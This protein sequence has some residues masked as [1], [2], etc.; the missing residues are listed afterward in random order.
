MILVGDQGRFRV[1]VQGAPAELSLIGAHFESKDPKRLAVDRNT[2]IYQALA[3]GKVLVGVTHPNATNAAV[4]NIEI[5]PR[6]DA[7]LIIRP[8]SIKLLVNARQTLKVALNSGKQEETVSLLSSN[9]GTNISIGQPDAVRWQPPVLTGLQST[10]PFEITVEHA[11]KTARAVV[12]VLGQGGD[13][14]VSPDHTRLSAGQAVS[15]SLEQQVPGTDQWQEIDPAKVT[16]EVPDDVR[17]TPAQSTLRPRVTPGESAQG[18]LTLTA[19]YAGKTAAME[20]EVATAA[21]PRGELQVVREPDGDEL[22]VGAQQRFAIVVQ[23][24]SDQLPAAGIQ[25]QPPFENDYVR[26]EP[27]ILLAKRAGHEQ[28]LTAAVG[29]DRVSFVARTVSQPAD[30]MDTPPPPSDKPSAVRIVTDQPQPIT[31]PVGSRF[32]EFRVEADYPGRPATDVTRQAALRASDR[33]SLTITRGV[34]VGKK[35]GAALLAATYN[36]VTTTDHLRFNVV[37]DAAL[38]DLSVSPESHQLNVGESVTLRVTGFVGDAENR[39]AIGDITALSEI[40]FQSDQPSV[41]RADGPTLTGLAVGNAKVTVVAGNVSTAIDV[42]VVPQDDLHDEPLA[43]SPRGLRIKVGESKLLGRDVVVRRGDADL[44]DQVDADSS[45]PETVRYHRVDR[46]VEGITAG[47]ATLTLKASG[48]TI[49]L[50]ILVEPDDQP[51]QGRVWVEP[52]SDTISVGQYVDLRVYLVSEDGQRIDRTGSATLVASDPQV[53]SVQRHRVTGI[54]AGNA[55]IQARLPGLDQAG[56]AS[57]EVIS[58]EF[59]S[60]QFLPSPLSVDVGQRESFRV[61]AVGPNG[62]RTLG[63]HPELK[64][65][66]TGSNP[67]AVELSGNGEIRGATPGDATLNVSWKGLQADPVTVRVLDRAVTGLRIDPSSASVE[68]NGRQRIQ[69]FA[70]RGGAET[71][72]T[73]DDGLRLSVDD[74]SVVSVDRDQSIRGI[75]V[76]RDITDSAIRF[77]ASGI[78]GDS[79]ARRGS[80]QGGG[81][82]GRIAVHS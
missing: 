36:G 42:E 40:Q 5:V 17:W 63:D 78:A 67:N 24:G 58:D 79:R 23:Q 68:L 53:L 15:P 1:T 46:S 39:M 47:R 61:Q 51:N 54:S 21:P 18:S 62:R 7:E 25:W 26:W 11:G 16:W 81:H 22:A 82:A 50:P 34:V 80:R 9:R 59:T 8:E 52:E 48:Q 71:A 55:T 49:S 33:N 44:S 70:T 13:L 38:T 6:Q 27:P 43:V 69:V 75:R 2:G 74:T 37:D 19:K 28:L 60:L 56:T 76:V 12:Q 41:V 14:R 32:E 72:V 65:S 3:P 57:F 4:E 35:P 77:S 66:V 29:D 31:L 45:D 30:P 73:A 20:L 10:E 64:I